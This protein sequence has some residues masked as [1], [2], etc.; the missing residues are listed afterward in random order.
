[1]TRRDHDTFNLIAKHP[2]LLATLDFLGPPPSSLAPSQDPK[3]LELGWIWILPW[4]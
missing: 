2:A 4:V 1:M 3:L